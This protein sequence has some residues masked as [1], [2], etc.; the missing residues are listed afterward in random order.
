M[1]IRSV[2]DQTNAYYID[3]IEDEGDGTFTF[4]LFRKE[5]EDYGRWFLT[6]DY[7]NTKYVE[8][9]QAIEAAKVAVSWFEGKVPL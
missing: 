2:E 8:L 7:S 9:G 3:F 6:A 1:I 4:K 5:P